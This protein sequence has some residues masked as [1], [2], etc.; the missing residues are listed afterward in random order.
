MTADEFVAKLCE[1]GYDSGSLHDG[2]VKVVSERLLEVQCEPDAH[3]VESLLAFMRFIGVTPER[4]FEAVEA[5][6]RETFG[7]ETT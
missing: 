2:A 6:D 4:L 1:G 5:H 3:P 7:K